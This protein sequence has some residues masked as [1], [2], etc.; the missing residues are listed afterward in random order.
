[1][2]SAGQVLAER[3]AVMI[4][5]WPSTGGWS[6]VR[7]HLRNTAKD[8]GPTGRD[9][10]YGYGLVDMYAAV[11]YNPVKTTHLSSPAQP[12][13]EEGYYQIDGDGGGVEW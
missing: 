12:V 10:V 1:M 8:L 5:P 4:P 6:E 2:S 3:S 7:D 9:N 13:A 11:A